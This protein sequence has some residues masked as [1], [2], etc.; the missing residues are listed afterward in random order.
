[1]T[2]GRYDKPAGD[3]RPSRYSKPDGDS[4]P[5]YDKPAGDS[6]PGR[7]DKPAGDSRPSRGGDSRP[8]SGGYRSD[9]P[10]ARAGGRPDS[11][12]GPKRSSSAGY[13]GVN[14]RP[15]K[16]AGR[17]SRYSD[18]RP[19]REAPRP[20]LAAK[21]NEPATPKGLDLRQLPRG[22]RAELRGLTS[23][24]AEIVGAHL[25]MA[26]QLIDSDPELAYAHAEAARR[27]AARLPITREAAGETAYAAGNFGTALNEF[28]ALRRMTGRDD[29]L[30]AMADCERALG[31]YQGALR[32]VKEGLA[33][34][35]EVVTRIELRLVEA[36]IRS[37]TG[38]VD[39]ALRLLKSEIEEL[40]TRGTKLARARLRYGYADLLERTGDGEQAERW[41]DAVIR[42]DPDE[43]T[44]AAD[45]VAALRGIVIE[46][47]DE[48]EEFFDEGEDEDED[49]EVVAEAEDV[50]D[51]VVAE[52]EVE[53]A[54][55]EASEPDDADQPGEAVTEIEFADLNDAV[56]I[57]ESEPGEVE[58]TDEQ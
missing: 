56:A 50:V 12:G 14:A 35:P 28:R 15:E 13:K 21:A 45:R 8:D 2:R 49:E 46:Y 3:S 43:T 34:N 37:Q 4:R 17:P 36:G 53:A 7:Y 16:L 41:F 25:L 19:P 32:L 20:G 26:G 33:K 48:D 29:Y 23:E 51:E 5:R 38:Q 1:D 31:R 52:A 55:D 30:A 22:V 6:R 42:L 9:R 27:R 44:D 54:E 47:V 39:E 11:A 40:G 57:D 58:D 18:A 10:A 24:H